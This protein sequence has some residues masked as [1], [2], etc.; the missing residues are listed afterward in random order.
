VSTISADPFSLRK[1]FEDISPHAGQ[2]WRFGELRGWGDLVDNL[3]VNASMIN[4]T[5]CVQEFMHQGVEIEEL[6][7]VQAWV[8]CYCHRSG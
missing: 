3:C 7:G 4:Q 1:S 5:C 2:N 6:V 8:K